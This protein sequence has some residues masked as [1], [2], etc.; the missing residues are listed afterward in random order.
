MSLI[1]N[2]LGYQI[3]WFVG[4][5]GAGRGSPWPGVLAA[6]AFAAWQLSCSP[7]RGPDLRLIGV[8]LVLG[9]VLDGSLAR[10][11]ILRYAAAY[12]ALP[13]GGAPFWI[14]SLWVAFA[15]TL[16]HSLRKVRDHPVQAAFVGGFGGPLAYAAAERLSGA[17]AITPPRWQGLTCLG[18]G[19]AAALVLLGYLATRWQPTMAYGGRKRHA[20]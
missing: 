15:L 6:A 12:P 17:V 8:A 1:G 18:A 14:L 13:P 3:V 2:I 5:Y 16:N 7:Q 9:V 4:V 19:W 11:R 10:A 20:S